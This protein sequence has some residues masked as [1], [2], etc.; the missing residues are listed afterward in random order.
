LPTFEHWFQGLQRA[1]QT[2]GC[3]LKKHLCHWRLLQD[4]LRGAQRPVPE[5][6]GR[7][8]PNELITTPPSVQVL[9]AK[10]VVGRA[11]P[12][13]CARRVLDL[14]A[15]AGDFTGHRS[16]QGCAIS[17]V[18]VVAA[19]VATGRQKYPKHRWMCGNCM[20]VAVLLELSRLSSA[21]LE[22]SESDVIVMNPDFESGLSA[23]LSACTCLAALLQSRQQRW[24]VQTM[25]DIATKGVTAGCVIALLPTD[26]FG[27]ARRHAALQSM[28]VSI[29]FEVQLGRVAY[30]AGRPTKRK[31][32]PDSL[33]V[34]R[35]TSSLCK[36]A[37]PCHAVT[38]AASWAA[39]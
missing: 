29:V 38:N 36:T 33:Y 7:L 18:E 20:D 3:S 5:Q 16:L 9:L 27:S 15:G 35:L 23:V 39:F 37:P 12:A 34:L 6:N 26:F 14:F 17:H 13:V 25:A 28:G 10:L 21:S 24:H 30:Y 2:G 19:R 4:K 31:V 32:S 1:G 8:H 11:R 22:A